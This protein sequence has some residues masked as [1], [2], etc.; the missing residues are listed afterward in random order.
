ME[1]INNFNNRFTIEDKDTLYCPSS[2]APVPSNVEN[3]ILMTDEIGNKAHK[4]LV[5][6]RLT[7][8]TPAFTRP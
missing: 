8:K 7:D 5:Q 4:K 3:D 6:D 1:A 2:G